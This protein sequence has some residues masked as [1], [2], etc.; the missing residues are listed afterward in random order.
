MLCLAVFAYGVIVFSFLLLGG[1]N[2]MLTT[3][4]RLVVLIVPETVTGFIPDLGRLRIL[5]ESLH[6]RNFAFGFF[7][8]A[9]ILED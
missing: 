8:F 5:G 9:I 6:V 2:V 1:V 4:L 7:G 3:C